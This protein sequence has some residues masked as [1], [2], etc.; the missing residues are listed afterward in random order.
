MSGIYI[1]SGLWLKFKGGG[2]KCSD[3]SHCS[4][5]IGFGVSTCSI[6]CHM[7]C[8]AAIMMKQQMP[9]CLNKVWV[10]YNIFAVIKVDILQSSQP[11]NWRVI[12]R[13]QA[14]SPVMGYSATK[15]PQ[16]GCRIIRTYRRRCTALV[17]TAWRRANAEVSISAN[18]DNDTSTCS[19]QLAEAHP[20]LT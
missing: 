5:Q 1:P 4:S 18:N 11:V 9:L 7:L 19:I 16:Y 12:R 3:A 15:W 14:H 13:H 6:Q 17:L 2:K 8:I 10:K 20:F